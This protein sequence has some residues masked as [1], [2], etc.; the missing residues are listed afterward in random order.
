M[1]G[2]N[3][4]LQT[5]QGAAKLAAGL[6][7]LREHVDGSASYLA[8][9]QTGCQ[10]FVIHYKS[11]AQIQEACAILHRSELILPKQILILR[12]AVDMQRHHVS[13]LQQFAESY[14]T[15]IAA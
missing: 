3:H 9:L 15:C 8:R 4:I 11:S 10:R 7:F 5:A 14:A 12:L 1:W 13:R 6:G 2:E